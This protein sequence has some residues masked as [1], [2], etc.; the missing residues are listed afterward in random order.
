MICADRRIAAARALLDFVETSDAFTRLMEQERSNV[1]ELSVVRN[2][3][4]YAQDDDVDYLALQ[5]CLTTADAL[6]DSYPDLEE[7][8]SLKERLRKN[9]R[10]WTSWMASQAGG[11]L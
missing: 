6:L 4:R 10:A 2:A 9:R 5:Q 7:A 3:A 8:A 1:I 11:E